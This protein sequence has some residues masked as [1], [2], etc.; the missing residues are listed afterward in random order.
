MK[1][2]LNELIYQDD[3][4][5]QV[6][7]HV[8]E[9]LSTPID[10]KEWGDKNGVSLGMF[11]MNGKIDSP[12]KH[13][14]WL[15]VHAR[16]VYDGNTRMQMR[17]PD[18]NV[19]YSNEHHEAR[20]QYNDK[21]ITKMAVL[22]SYYEG[23]KTEVSPGYYFNRQKDKHG[24]KLASTEHDY[25][26]INS[27]GGVIGRVKR[28][29]S[30]LSFGNTETWTTLNVTDGDK[31]YNYTSRD[32]TEGDII[33]QVAVKQNNLP[34][35]TSTYIKHP[36][37]TETLFQTGVAGAKKL[38]KSPADSRIIEEIYVAVNHSQDKVDE[39]NYQ[40]TNIKS[41]NS[42]TGYPTKPSII[43]PKINPN[44]KATLAESIPAVEGRIDL[45][46]ILPSLATLQSAK[47]NGFNLKEMIVKN[48]Y[49]VGMGYK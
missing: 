6:E 17:S 27:E 39:K 3:R 26:I 46:S 41:Y 20:S 30:Q 10:W 35:H 45:E 25:P 49:D 42:L 36:N 8:N 31:S 21:R 5:S 28:K 4:L 32:A 48:T 18:Y 1:T 29:T 24:N 7:G 14:C 43:T 2:R 22:P 38:T 44:L 40:L 33:E 23:E 12:V 16:M 9:L 37:S 15:Q 47:E 11:T 13:N 34:I 19:E